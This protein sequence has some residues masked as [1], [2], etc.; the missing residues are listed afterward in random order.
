MDPERAL[1]SAGP[2]SECDPKLVNAGSQSTN[3]SLG[4]E[5]CT[6]TSPPRSSAFFLSDRGN[7][8]D[9]HPPNLQFHNHDN[10]PHQYFEPVTMPDNSTRSISP[11]GPSSLSEARASGLDPTRTPPI[12]ATKPSH[13]TPFQHLPPNPD[14]VSSDVRRSSSDDQLM[15]L[16]GG[17]QRFSPPFLHPSSVRTK[18]PRRQPPFPTST[19][20]SKGGKNP[21]TRFTVSSSRPNSP[22]EQGPEHRYHA[23][24]PFS[25][26]FT[27]RGFLALSAFSKVIAVLFVCCV[28]LLLRALLGIGHSAESCGVFAHPVTGTVGLRSGPSS[29]NS[30]LGPD[31]INLKSP[32]DGDQGEEDGRGRAWLEM[33]DEIYGYQYDWKL[34]EHEIEQEDDGVDRYDDEYEH[35]DFLDQA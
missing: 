29:E 32:T 12:G 30:A 11:G 27:I 4:T 22:I 13:R 16:G 10:P 20:R 8:Y 35:E 18:S 15:K 2:D 3:V 21:R 26:P 31:P 25:S 19:Q 34:A 33:V 6:S 17:G 1:C 28:F 14:L 5:R 24:N 7:Q 23:T 9:L